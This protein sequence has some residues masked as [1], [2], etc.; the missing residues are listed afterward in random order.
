MKKQDVL[1]W[2]PFFPVYIPCEVWLNRCLTMYLDLQ[3]P[4]WRCL[5]LNSSVPKQGCRGHC[6][7]CKFPVILAIKRMLD[8]WSKFSSYK[9]VGS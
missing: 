9:F 3:W 4:G 7:H 2:T 6:L 1:I 5:D 8:T